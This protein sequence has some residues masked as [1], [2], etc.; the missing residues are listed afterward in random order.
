MGI[1]VQTSGIQVDRQKSFLVNLNADPSLNELLVYYLKVGFGLYAWIYLFIFSDSIL[2]LP[3]KFRVSLIMAI[4]MYMYIYFL[5]K[6][7]APPP[8][9]QYYN[10]QH[11]FTEKNR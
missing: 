7:Y 9:L 2:G 3:P 6:L 10:V 8:P 5:A 1:S 4:Y 11:N